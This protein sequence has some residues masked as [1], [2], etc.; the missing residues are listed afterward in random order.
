MLGITSFNQATEISKTFKTGLAAAGHNV[1]VRVVGLSTHRHA[2]PRHAYVALTRFR[3]L[4]CF[5]VPPP[6]KKNTC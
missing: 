6:V 1:T 3:R 5:I 4:V 2:T